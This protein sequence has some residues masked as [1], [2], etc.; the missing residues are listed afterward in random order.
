MKTIMEKKN[1]KQSKFESSLRKTDE[2]PCH[3]R[4]Q[5]PK[6]AVH[7]FPQLAWASTSEKADLSLF[8]HRGKDHLDAALAQPASSSSIAGYV[9]RGGKALKALC[10]TLSRNATTSHLLVSV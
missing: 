4:E 8:N 7:Q 2:S 3:H 9:D 6:D 1:R 5:E 10:L